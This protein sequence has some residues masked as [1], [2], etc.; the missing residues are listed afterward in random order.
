MSSGY[1]NELWNFAINPIKKQALSFDFSRVDLVFGRFAFGMNVYGVP[2][3]WDLK[4]DKFVRFF[5]V[6]DQKL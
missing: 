5:K 2:T 4:E 3:V 1:F 6:Y